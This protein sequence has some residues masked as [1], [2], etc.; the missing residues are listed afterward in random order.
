[1]WELVKWE[2]RHLF[3]Q[4]AIYVVLFLIA[5][6]IFLGHSVIDT[7]SKPA[8]DELEGPISK[9][10]ITE[11]TAA[12]STAPSYY[13]NP[14]YTVL[15][16]EQ[17]SILQN[18]KITELKKALSNTPND[19]EIKKEIEYR[20]NLDVL[21]L[22]NYQLPELV[23]EYLSSEGVIFMG[24]LLIIGLYSIFSRDE[25][26]GVSQYTLTSKYGRTKLVTA[27]IM[28]SFIYTL[29]VYLVV[30]LFT[31]TYQ[32][33]RASANIS[34]WKYAFEGWEAPIQF[35]SELTVSPYPFSIM[36]YHAIQLGF[37]FL[38]SLALT[39]IFLA[40]SS[41]SKNSFISFLFCTAIFFVPIIIV[42]IVKAVPR[43][44]WLNAIYPYSPTYTMKAEA[45]FGTF[46]SIHAGS[47][48]VIGPY[49]AL[50]ITILF[51]TGSILFLKWYV[52]N[53]K[54]I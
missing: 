8:Y 4:K 34:Y 50:I 19:P 45:L 42:D 7:S 16:A 31:W 3:R 14:Y 26:T 52:G 49:L 15:Y 20:N 46:R 51:I 43:I 13:S 44:G 22:T 2:S 23:V 5:C 54:V 17:L 36:E 39:L 27:K 6:F 53:Q 1:M 38:G 37:L 9:Q 21:Y 47:L 32:I 33:Y 10:D 48:V 12:E 29:V 40:V 24:A 35:L 11:A 41:V 30:T 18:E 25:V 28:V